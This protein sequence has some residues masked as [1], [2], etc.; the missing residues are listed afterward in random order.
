MFINRS[1]FI[2][3]SNN[4]DE[5]LSEYKLIALE[6]N[7]KILSLECEE[8]LNQLIPADAVAQVWEECR[9]RTVTRCMKIPTNVADKI[10][11]TDDTKACYKILEAEINAALEE[12]SRYESKN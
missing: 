12:L 5:I 2:P 3:K 6:A 1:E 9:E 8:R 7:A 4:K 10:A 11:E